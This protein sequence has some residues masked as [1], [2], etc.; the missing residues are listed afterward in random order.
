VTPTRREFLQTGLVASLL[1]WAIPGTAL[2]LDDDIA[3]DVPGLY[4]VVVDIRFAAGAAFA[5]DADRL[6]ASLVRITGDITDFWFHDLSL[7]W[8]QSPVPIAGL[9]GHGPLFCLER[10]AWDHGLRVV[11][12]REHERLGNGVEP[13]IS[14]VI[15]PARLA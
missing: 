8:K 4:K 15:A 6:G 14:W 13:L 10:F 3:H 9:T 7:R 2:A 5:D 1:P 12:R 11:V